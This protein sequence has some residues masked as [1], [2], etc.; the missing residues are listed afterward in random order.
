M[1]ALGDVDSFRLMTRHN[2]SDTQSVS[3]VNALR[4]SKTL[5]RI[6]QRRG[7]LLLTPTV[8]QAAVLRTLGLARDNASVPRRRKSLCCNA[9]RDSYYVPHQGSQ[10]QGKSWTGI[11]IMSGADIPVCRYQDYAPSRTFKPRLRQL[12]PPGA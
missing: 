2:T 6:K 9:T 8:G 10:V 12:P 7:I 1:I 4:D 5:E 11:Q 3:L